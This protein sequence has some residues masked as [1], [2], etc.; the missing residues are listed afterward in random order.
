MKRKTSKKTSVAAS[1]LTNLI[2]PY[3]AGWV[4]LSPDERQVVAAASTIQESQERASSQG[5]PHPI[6]VK[7]L[8]PDRGYV[9]ARV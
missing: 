7:V 8:P 2:R 5:Y 9:P 6:F 4:A 1:D 3:A